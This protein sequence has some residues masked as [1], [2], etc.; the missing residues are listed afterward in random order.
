M[1]SPD[2]G[3]SS[4]PRSFFIASGV[5][6]ADGQHHAGPRVR[7]PR[8]AGVVALDLG[9]SAQRGVTC[10]GRRWGVGAAYALPCARAWCCGPRCSPV[11]VRLTRR[12]AL[13]RR[14]RTAVKAITEVCYLRSFHVTD[15]PQSI[16]RVDMG[17]VGW[18][19]G[20]IYEPET[21]RRGFSIQSFSLFIF[22]DF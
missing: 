18:P 9:I 3:A 14:R 15:S 6:R 22:H 5:E 11:C 10:V 20:G 16:S 21:N 4:A 13:G 2:L 1:S 8:F 19:F 12:A 17:M 7:Y